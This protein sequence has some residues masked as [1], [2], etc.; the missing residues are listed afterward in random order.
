MKHSR[1]RL[2]AQEPEVEV[3]TAEQASEAQGK[4]LAQELEPAETNL[5]VDV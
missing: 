4:L 3:E 1:G 2:L 5:E